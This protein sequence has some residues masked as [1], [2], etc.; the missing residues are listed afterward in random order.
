MTGLVAALRASTRCLTLASLAS[1]RS[2]SSEKRSPS[3]NSSVQHSSYGDYMAAE[4]F[5]LPS[6]TW[7][8]ARH[9]VGLVAHRGAS[10]PYSFGIEGE[11]QFR[12][13]ARSVG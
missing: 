12:M 4:H 1:R 2:A 3:G 5:G 6:V 10:H 9:A 7:L 13:S 11:G 8:D